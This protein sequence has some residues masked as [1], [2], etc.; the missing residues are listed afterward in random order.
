MSAFTQARKLTAEL[1]ATKIDNSRDDE[2]YG[3][4]ITRVLGGL[5][6]LWT[7]SAVTDEAARIK[8]DLLDAYDKAR[9]V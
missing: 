1:A 3:K 9:G 7:N 4:R 6:C 8:A 5:N 2:R